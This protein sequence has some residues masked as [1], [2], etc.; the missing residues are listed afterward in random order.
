MH[1]HGYFPRGNEK[2][3]GLTLK[4]FK[5]HLYCYVIFIESTLSVY[6]TTY[7]TVFFTLLVEGRGRFLKIFLASGGV[8]I[9][10]GGAYLKLGANSSIYGT[11]I[12]QE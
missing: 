9:R 2:K 7:S 11:C 8:L 3:T 5:E 1:S 10:R 12:Y 6:R 4:D